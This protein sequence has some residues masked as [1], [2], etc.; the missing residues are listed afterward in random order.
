MNAFH[1]TYK[2]KGF[3]VHRCSTMFCDISN[4]KTKTHPYAPLTH[5]VFVYLSFNQNDKL[6][7][8]A[9]GCILEVARLLDPPQLNTYITLYNYI[10]IQFSTNVPLI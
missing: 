3:S 1:K 4:T 2:H 10:T 7:I 6:S 5:Y 8:T 9:E